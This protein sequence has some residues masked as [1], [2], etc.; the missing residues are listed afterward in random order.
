MLRPDF[1]TSTLDFP[2]LIRYTSHLIK[3]LCA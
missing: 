3:T 1:P 2:F